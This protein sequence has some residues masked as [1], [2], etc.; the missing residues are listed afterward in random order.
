MYV[1]T[2]LFD[3]VEGV[4]IKIGYEDLD[5]IPAVTEDLSQIEWRSVYVGV[6][7]VGQQ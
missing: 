2:Q 3:L 7:G 6:E 1:I 5:F 4:I